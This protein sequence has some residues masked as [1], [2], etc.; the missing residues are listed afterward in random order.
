MMDW[1]QD[2]IGNSNRLTE[3]ARRSSKGAAQDSH[4]TG[5]THRLDDRRDGIAVE[6]RW[7]IDTDRINSTT[8]SPVSTFRQA[9]EGHTDSVADIVLADYNRAVISAGD[10]ALVMIWRPHSESQL[11]PVQLGCHSDY[12]RT[13]A[14]A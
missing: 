12:I 13:L 2:G 3:G 5:D 8:S 9:I 10:D 1:K 14:I 11:A 6:D 7:E 4:N